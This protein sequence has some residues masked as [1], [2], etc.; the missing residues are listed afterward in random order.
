MHLQKYYR[1]I[2]LNFENVIYRKKN[3]NKN[4]HF[5]NYTIN[6]SIRVFGVFTYLIYQNFSKYYIT[7][8]PQ[9]YLVVNTITRHT[10]VFSPYLFTGLM[11]FLLVFSYHLK[12]FY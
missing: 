6:L 3:L 9:R 2:K 7:R 11:W 4:N 1:F 5:C 8:Y 12:I 10:K